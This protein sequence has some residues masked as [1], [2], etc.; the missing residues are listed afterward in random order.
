MIKQ[1]LPVSYT[2]CT[3][4]MCYVYYVL[5]VYQW[6]WDGCYIKTVGIGIGGR[7]NHVKILVQFLLSLNLFII[8][9][10]AY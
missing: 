5:Y 1:D 9:N 7:P 8:L 6:Y 10:I 4:Y 2:R 3:G